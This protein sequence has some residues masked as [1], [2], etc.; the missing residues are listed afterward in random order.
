MCTRRHL[1]VRLV[2]YIYSETGRKIGLLLKKKT[3]FFGN[4]KGDIVFPAAVV[5]LLKLSGVA[6]FRKGKAVRW[7]VRV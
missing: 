5:R 2:P 7:L 3:G 6:A 1:S 4:W